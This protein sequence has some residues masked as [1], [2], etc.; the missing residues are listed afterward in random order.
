MG[1]LLQRRSLFHACI[2]FLIVQTSFISLSFNFVHATHSHVAVV[3]PYTIT[4]TIYDDYNQN[5]ILDAREPGISG[6]TVTAYDSN[7]ANAGSTV[8]LAD[9]S[10]SLAIGSG[11]GP[12]RVQFTGFGPGAATTELASFY[13]SRHGTDNPTSVTFVDGSNATNTLNFGLE[14]PSDY[15]QHNPTIATNCYVQGD[16]ANAQ[17]HVLVSFPYNTTGAHH[18]LI[19]ATAPEVGSTWGLAYRRSTDTLFAASYFKRHAG[20]KPGGDPGAIYVV[21]GAS[22]GSPRVQ[23]TP[24]VTLPAGKNLHDASNYLTDLSAFNQ[25]GKVSL[26]G[27]AL[28]QDESTLYV[29]NLFDQSLYAVPLGAASAA[30]VAQTPTAY[31]VPV[32]A[33]CQATGDF[34]PFAVSQ[35]HG[36]I[37]VGA[38]CSAESTVPANGSSLGDYSKLQ[39]YLF[40]FIPGRGFQK[41]PIFHFPLNYPRYCTNDSTYSKCTASGVNNLNVGQPAMWN[42]WHP[43]YV[44]Y[45]DHLSNTNNTRVYPQPMFTEIAFDN[46]NLLIGLRDRFGDQMGYQTPEPGNSS[47]LVSAATAGDILRA[48]LRQPGNLARG[49]TLEGNA[50]CGGVTT[51][52]AGNAQRSGGAYPYQ[53]NHLN[54]HDGGS[55][56]SLLQVPGLADVISTQVNPLSRSSIA[57]SGG[58]RTY[59]NTLGTAVNNYQIYERSTPGVF[60][61][62]NGLGALVAFCASA[63]IEIGNRVWG[64]LNNNG[65]QDANEPPIAGVTIDLYDAT[66]T[67]LIATTTTAA[68]GTYYFTI[69]SYTSYV[70]KL[71]KAS[72][73][74][75]GGPLAG[76]GLTVANQDQNHLIDSKA[77][78][79]NSAQMIGSGNYPQMAVLPHAPGQ[80]DHT[81]DAGFTLLPDL[82]I[83]NVTHDHNFDRNYH[84]HNHNHHHNHSHSGNDN[85]N[86][87]DNNFN[88]SSL[89]DNSDNNFNDSSL[90]DNGDNNFSNSCDGCGG[91]SCDG[92]GGGSCDGCGGGTCDSCGGGTC[93]GGS[94]DSGFSYSD[95]LGDGGTPGLPP[96][97]ANPLL[98]VRLH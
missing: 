67:N 27:M 35:Y 92:C 47:N 98:A 48:C 77:T 44:S 57:F 65:I 43:G 66:G 76:L 28:S 91:G 81:F 13:P 23:A 89:S 9:G 61:K 5:G 94:C 88:D 38:V 63:P 11:T 10:Y 96:A 62:A 41:Q 52:G 90:S 70:I 24:L 16:Q 30:P 74:V 93:G 36:S 14:N 51:A 4:G 2:L 8:S 31:A 79:P 60:G 32:P 58:V 85:S 1:A 46:G 6:V 26:G 40:R 75:M 49:W 59:D 97:G 22:S 20:F 45:N 53:D 80:N 69:Q 68:D 50:S 15:C 86:F 64:D 42:P 34:R 39:A 37:Y 73:Y 72:D 21:D 17:S 78:V 19:M 12:V 83:P 87:G 33:D 54:I 82:N 29:M 95:G 71:D 25:V 18:P 56:G 84:N 3:A 7:N 55:F